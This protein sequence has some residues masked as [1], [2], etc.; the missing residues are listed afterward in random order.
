MGG[1][2]V[3][4]GRPLLKWAK[5]APPLD[6][7]NYHRPAPHTHTRHAGACTPTVINEM[8]GRLPAPMRSHLWFQSDPSCP[9][10]IAVRRYE[11]DMASRFAFAS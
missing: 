5:T 6:G 8:H 4:M 1:G 7:V 3:N 10:A 2:H 9:R 11:S